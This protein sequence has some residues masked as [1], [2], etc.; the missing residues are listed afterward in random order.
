MTRSAVEDQK[1]YEDVRP[2]FNTQGRPASKQPRP[3]S[4]HLQRG[5]FTGMAFRPLRPQHSATFRL[6]EASLDPSNRRKGLL[7]PESARK[8]R[9]G[10]LNKVPRFKTKAQSKGTSS[11][12]PMEGRALP[13]FYRSYQEQ[14]N[15][16]SLLTFLKTMKRDVAVSDDEDDGSTL[17]VSLTEQM[18]LAKRGEDINPNLAQQQ[19]LHSI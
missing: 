8:L 18:A 3:T 9:T 10:E 16:Y 5:S 13:D 15:Q 7:P 1:A 14:Q 17:D 4:G 6:G 12:A 2:A 19:Q 11:A